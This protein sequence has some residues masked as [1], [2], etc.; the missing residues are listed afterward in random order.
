MSKAQTSNGA[1]LVRD[2][3][4]GAFISV[5]GLGALKDRMVIRKGIDLTK[6]IAAQAI[7]GPGQSNGQISQTKR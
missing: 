2:A 1:T 5:R 7:K 6:P 4:S 3:K